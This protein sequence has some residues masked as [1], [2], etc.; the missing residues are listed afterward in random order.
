VI[1]ELDWIRPE[2]AIAPDGG[3]RWSIPSIAM[4]NER[5]TGMWCGQTLVCGGVYSEPSG[6]VSSFP[7]RW[8]VSR[9]RRV[10]QT[11]SEGRKERR[12]WST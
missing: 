4:R 10:R 11:R 8:D 9:R 12:K 3:R 7:L 1:R 6:F 5:L 2:A